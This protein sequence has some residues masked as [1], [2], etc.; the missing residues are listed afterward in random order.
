MYSELLQNSEEKVLII[1]IDQRF[2]NNDK[3]NE[4]EDNNSN[5][6]IKELNYENEMNSL[7]KL[8]V[9]FCE[10]LDFSDDEKELSTEID[11]DNLSINENQNKKFIFV[12]DFL[13][14]NND[15]IKEIQNKII[16][17]YQ[18]HINLIDKIKAI[19]KN[20][21]K[22]DNKNKKNNLK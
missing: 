3:T 9:K 13:N 22:Q 21:K 2:I 7:E 14:I 4:E 20:E 17:D 12:K 1:A 11:S 19:F 16:I 6:L 8:N 15:V 10:S 18:N 5:E